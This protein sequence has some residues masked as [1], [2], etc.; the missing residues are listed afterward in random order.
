MTEKAPVHWCFITPEYPPTV[1]GV[2]DYTRLVA[3]HLLKAGQAVSVLAPTRGQPPI[4]N[5]LDV[6]PVLGE[7]GPIG[8][9]RG[10]KVL[11]GLPRPRRLFLQWVPHGFGFK[12]MNLLLVLW[13][14]WRVVVRR[15]QLWIMVHEPFL[16]FEKSWKQRVAASIHRVM[17]W[18]LLAC[19]DQIFAG[20]KLWI[21]L[22][23]FWAPKGKSIKW[24]P[25]PSCVPDESNP[26]IANSIKR[27]FCPNG[28][29]IG[30]F[31]TYGSNTSIPLKSCFEKLLNQRDRV[32]ALFIGKNSDVFAS[33]LITNNPH[34]DC[35]VFGTGSIVSKDLSNYIKACDFF[36]QLNEE[37]LSTR[38][39]SLM[40]ILN[41]G[42]TGVGNVGA[43]TDSDWGFWEGFQVVESLQVEQKVLYFADN[44]QTIPEME[45]LAKK[46]YL[47][48]F[49]LEIVCKKLL[50]F[51]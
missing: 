13:I 32:N 6:Q 31:G 35:R 38:N 2:A 40:T 42:K 36:V 24:L 41:I 43:V 49:S 47:D 9:W 19:P 46:L 10:S 26:D 30:S 16:R 17:V 11:D 5:G 7:F 28:I 33:S 45:A 44:P 14:W 48:N 39:S 3:T 20:N 15:D 22:L 25:V 1:G 51:P 23:S 21:N 34:F 8:F 18:V 12:S 4:D 37:G 27:K 50:A 29:L